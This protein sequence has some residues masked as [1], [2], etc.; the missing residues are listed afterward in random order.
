MGAP[1]D[2]LDE[3][4][5]FDR[6][7]WLLLGRGVPVGVLLRLALLPTEGLRDDTDQFAGWVHVIATEGLGGL[8]VDN[9]F[10]PVTFGPV[11]GFIWWL[12][13][14]IQ[15]M[16]A[17]V[18]D[19][20]DVGIRML[21]KT[22]ASLADLGLAAVAAYAL[23]GRPALAVLAASVILL[24][25]AVIDVSA[26]WGQYESIYVLF[27]L[28]AVVVAV[29]GRNGVA[30]ALIAV[31][32]MTKPQ[33]IAFIVPF[34]AWFWATGYGRDGVRGGIV[35]L[36]KTGAIGGA[37]IA[38]LWLPFVPSGGPQGYLANLAT[39]QNE[40]FN[41]LS[42]R[43]WNVWWL[44]QEAAVGGSF[45]ADDVPFAGPLTLRHIG[46]GIT[47]L[48]QL[49]IA[50][51]IIRDPRPR[52]FILGIVASVLVVFTFM[53]QMHERYAYAAVVVLVLLIAEPRMRWL[54][55]GLGVVFTLNFLAAIPPTPR[56]GELLPIAGPLGVA[57]SIAMIVITV[58]CLWALTH[59]RQD[60]RVEAS[61]RPGSVSSGGA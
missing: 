30:A 17:T 61:L 60:H 20:A 49:V 38:L 10:G 39:Y 54:A 22:P 48:L 6:R 11:M 24:D 47:A 16:F 2:V 15:P 3:G 12:M 35:E 37:T 46:Y 1:A 43:A 55:L 53:T 42:L 36:V 57:G 4:R 50:L 51:A 52:T 13:A 27:A 9:P 45:I 59:G 26:W 32:L 31:A 25:P 19:A 23:R 5:G 34:A 33:A 18:T 58:A 41:I 40:I 7:E 44:V 56:I 29:N 8:Y 28:A 14:A 21:L